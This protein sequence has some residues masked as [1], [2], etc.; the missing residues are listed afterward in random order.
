M[1][2]PKAANASTC[3]MATICLIALAVP[4]TVWADD[5]KTETSKD[6]RVVVSHRI[7]DVV[8]AQG[9][10]STLLEYTSTMTA[11]VDLRKVL[12]VLR[13]TSQHAAIHDDESSRTVRAISETEQILH[14]QLKMPWPLP[15]TD[16]V[17]R[18]VVT[19]DSTKGLATV[20]LDGAPDELPEGKTRRIRDYSTVYELKDLGGGRT[21]ITARVRVRPPFE[22]PRWLLFAGFPEA[23]AGT[24]K[25][26]TQFAAK[27][28]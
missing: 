18:M 20:T 4:Q 1:R 23:P 21:E 3:L 2:L 28:S 7:S 10:K 25:R 8:D 12:A 22:L 17:V 19:D 6:K 16:C 27:E 5:W 26:L 15:R 13:D 9:A 24:L 11:S 14:Y